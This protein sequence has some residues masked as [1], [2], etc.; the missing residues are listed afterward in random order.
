MLTEQYE[1]GNTR[2]PHG[3]SASSAYESVLFELEKKQQGLLRSSSTARWRRVHATIKAVRSTASSINALFP[4]GTS[5]SHLFNPPRGASAS[6]LS[7]SPR[8]ASA[9]QVSN[10]LERKSSNR[11]S[12]HLGRRNSRADEMAKEAEAAQVSRLPVLGD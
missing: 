12:L 10:G 8:G 9:S 3:F 2:A 6:H 5:S 4:R 11:K 7:N 1:R